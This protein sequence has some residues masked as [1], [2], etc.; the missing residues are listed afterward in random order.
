MSYIISISIQPHE[1]N[2]AM[3]DG[4]YNSAFKSVQEQLQPDASY[5]TPME[6]ARG[7]HLIIN[8][9]D[10]SQIS[11]YDG[12]AISRTGRDCR[13]S[14]RLYPRGCARDNGANRVSSTEVRLDAFLSGSGAFGASAL[15]FYL[16]SEFIGS[17]LPQ[18]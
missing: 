6:G 1:G 3:R 11:G 14:P 10:A 4:R 18:V 5:F 13:V 9:D 7:G 15:F 12:T 17:S 2:A 16:C 8:M